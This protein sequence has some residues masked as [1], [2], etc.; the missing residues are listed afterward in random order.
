MER[1]LA[2]FSLLYSRLLLLYP[3]SFRIRFAAEMAQVFQELTRETYRKSGLFGLLRLGLAVVLDSAWSALMQWRERIFQGRSTSMD[4]SPTNH[5][6]GITPLSIPGALAAVFPFLAFGA[7][8]LVSKLNLVNPGPPLIPFWQTLVLSPYLVFNW[9]ILGGLGVGIFKGFPRWTYSY[10]LWA[11]LFGWWWTN[12]S[13]F[14][15]HW[16]YHIWL[17]FSAAIAVP[18]LLKRSLQPL[19]ALGRGFWRDWTLLALGLYIFYCSVYLIADENHHP[20]LL[21]FIS[22]STLVTC[23]GA[24]GYFR[25]VRPL[26]RVLALLGGLLGVIVLGIISE[27]TW[28]YRA[29]YGLPEGANT[30]SL[31][32]LILFAGLAVLMLGIGLLARWRQK[33]QPKM[34]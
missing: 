16:H 5:D 31:V 8:S 9:I 10:L 29:Y 22:F 3:P 30:V 26:R 23:L 15:Y 32:G 7:A 4:T 2:I 25:Q 18:L 34:N 12:M 20:Y 19:K 6:D 21:L 1:L 28:D 13:S 11:L 33:R 27:S 24:W 17:P 14:G